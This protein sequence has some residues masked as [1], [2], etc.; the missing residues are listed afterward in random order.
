M[1][2][3]CFNFL[4]IIFFEPQQNVFDKYLLQYFANYHIICD[5]SYTNLKLIKN[6]SRVICFYNR[7]NF[8]KLKFYLLFIVLKKP[9]TPLKTEVHV[10]RCNL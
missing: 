1:T 10:V 6:Q 5:A 7:L 4:K 2:T 8:D 9:T 3:R